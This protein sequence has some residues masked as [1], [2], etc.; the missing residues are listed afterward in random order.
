TVTTTGGIDSIAK[1]DFI[2]ISDNTLALF[3]ALSPTSSCISSFQQF[4]VQFE[5]TSIGEITSRKW[6]INLDDS[7]FSTSPSPIYHFENAGS[8]DITLIVDGVCGIDSITK[9]DFIVLSEPITSGGFTISPVTGTVDSVFTFT[10]T[11]PIAVDSLTWD[12]GDGTPPL[13][14][15]S[16][17]THSYSSVGTYI[18]SLT[19]VNNCDSLQIIDSVVVSAP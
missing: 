5:D 6:R 11:S 4:L 19:L 9:T 3:R 18:V 7:V 2:S 13:F 12:F 17:V 15:S 16:V 8:Y 1:V 14:D 10:N